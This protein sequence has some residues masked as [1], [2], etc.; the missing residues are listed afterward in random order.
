MKSFFRVTLIAA[1]SATL[2]ACAS[3]S[4]PRPPVYQVQAKVQDV[5]P[6][7]EI[8]EEGVEKRGSS[9]ATVLGAVLGGVIGNQFGKGG[10]RVAATVVGAG[11]GAMIASPSTKRTGKMNCYRNGYIAVVSYIDPETQ[12]MVTKGVPLEK[13]TRAEFL[14]IPVE[15]SV[16]VSY[17]QH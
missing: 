13:N 17:H 4:Q 11:A 14:M 3:T 6:A 10:G 2:L 7:P 8:C 5:Y 9:G 12:M 15:G 16:P 1:L